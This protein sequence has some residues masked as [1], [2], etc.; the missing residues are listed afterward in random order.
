MLGICFFFFFRAFAD[1]TFASALV[2][3]QSERG[4]HVVSTGV[5]GIVRHP[6]YLGASLLMIGTPMLLGSVCGLVV[7]AIFTVLLMARI[8]GEERM[9]V[10]ELEG[11]AEYR[12]KV[13][14]RLVPY[15]W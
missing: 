2:R 8:V 3:I 5:Y 10:E 11:Y 6:M 9:L 4:H 13:K 14:Y 1:N 15:V 12:E 7:G